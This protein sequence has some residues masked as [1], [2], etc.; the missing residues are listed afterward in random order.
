[1]LEL[2]HVRNLAIVEDAKVSFGEGMNVIT[3]ETGAGKSILIGALQLILGGRADR[4]MLRTG[5][6]Q[7]TVQAD[8][9]LKDTDAVNTLLQEAD[10]DPCEDGNLIIRRSLTAAGTG[11]SS[12][13]DTNVTVAMLRRIG[14]L[15]VDMHG[16]HDHQSLLD[17]DFQ[18][19]VLD[20]FAQ[21][22][23]LLRD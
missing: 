15:L 9:A 20:S 17:P 2:L 5:E 1:M 23:N 12:V 7:L 8:F 21:L 10:I 14:R 4:S 3:G 22:G 6:Q 13:N 11:K 16:P 18:L 19:D